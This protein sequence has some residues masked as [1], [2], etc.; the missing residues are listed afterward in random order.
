MQTLLF[1]TKPARHCRHSELSELLTWQLTG[2]Q[3]P[4]SWANLS[5]QDK[6]CTPSENTQ[7]LSRM[8]LPEGLSPKGEEQS[9]HRSVMPSYCWQL[10]GLAGQRPCLLR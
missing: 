5:A 6:H 2:W 1:L 8:Q 3:T 4:F 9:T 7:L 10:E